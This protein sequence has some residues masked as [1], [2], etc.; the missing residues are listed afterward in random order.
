MFQAGLVKP[1]RLLELYE[2]VEPALYC[3]PAIDPA[4]FRGKVRRA[5]EDLIS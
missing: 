4:A 3:Y 1:G 5:V 2:Q